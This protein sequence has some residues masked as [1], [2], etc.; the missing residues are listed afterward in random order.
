MKS[1]KMTTR[2]LL[3]CLFVIFAYLAYGSG[4]VRATIIYEWVPSSE[5]G[6]FG[7]ITLT[8]GGPAPT[9]TDF[10]TSTVT[11]F[12]FTFDNGAPTV[13]LLDIVINQAPAAV[14][15]VITGGM[16]FR[17]DPTF[18]DAELTFAAASADYSPFVPALFPAE[19]NGGDWVLS[20]LIPEP[21][22]QVP[23]PSTLT[24]F[25]TGLA[26]LGFMMRRRRRST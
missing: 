17:E 21:S 15:G 3:F 10:T 24:L 22:T 13:T 20:S 18:T 25:V 9:E 23:E 7:A 14:G 19:S 11:D 12:Q 4:D 8:P 1:T 5:Q 2:T 26:G 6:A 16:I